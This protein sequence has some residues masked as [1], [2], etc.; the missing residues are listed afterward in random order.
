[1]SG[2]SSESGVS[3]EVNCFKISSPE[4]WLS[5]SAVKTGFVFKKG[6]PA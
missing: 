1:M 3:Y 2:V 4:Y 6:R 5:V